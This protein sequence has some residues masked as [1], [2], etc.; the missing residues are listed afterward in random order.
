M[1]K[2]PVCGVMMGDNVARCFMCKYDFQKAAREGEDVAKKEAT[3][4]IKKADLETSSRASDKKAE[5]DKILADAKERNRL[6][7]ESLQQQLDEE[8]LRLEEEYVEIRKK[9]FEEKSKIDKELQAA[10]KQVEEE[11]K[12]IEDVQLLH[13]QAV[14]ESKRLA[15][16][17]G[18]VIRKEAHADAGKIIKEAN[19]QTEQL[20]VQVRKEYEEAMNLKD[21]MLTEAKIHQAEAEEAL[22]IQKEAQTECTRIVSITEAAKNNA[23]QELAEVRNK[24]VQELLDSKKQAELDADA[25]VAAA[26]AA[27]L[28]AVEETQRVILEIENTRKQ[29]EEELS[30]Y[31]NEAKAAIATTEEAQQKARKDEEE[32]RIIL[33]QLKA[34]KEK[35]EAE[36]I[37]AD[38]ALRVTAEELRA[39]Q[40]KR[41]KIEEETGDVLLMSEE[42][43]KKAEN[44]VSER[45]NELEN[46]RTV[47]E[48][49]IAQIIEESRL[50]RASAEQEAALLSKELEE[51]RATIQQA[52]ERRLAAKAETETMR[53]TTKQETEELRLSAKDEAE[54]I[55][56][57]AEKRAVALKEAAISESEK[58]RM[59]K[60][61][62][63]NI[64]LA[65]Q[66]IA[67]KE[68]AEKRADALAQQIEGSR[69]AIEQ[70]EEKIEKLRSSQGPGEFKPVSVPME[71]EVE[72]IK[73][74]AT[75]EV[76]SEAISRALT[77][78]G[79]GGWKLHSLVNDEGGRLQASLG[80]SEQYSLSSGTAIKEDRVILI[81]E[82]VALSPSEI[83]GTEKI[84]SSQA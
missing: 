80:A 20:A 14:V 69:K 25:R 82:R 22:R 60:Q 77:K 31:I 41:D 28:K 67:A 66:A 55:I 48:A 83:E 13:D 63:E 39:A 84:P 64:L 12:H 40:E 71:Y 52:E 49:E 61:I 19:D 46:T 32:A 30:Y 5:E 21:Q 59:A 9:A 38:E 57:A 4:H 76:D 42:A 70:M 51:A 37:K 72:I 47:T 1:K 26:E 16:A 15:L 45:L 29:G 44:E 56:I 43:R 10:R 81:F 50:T 24:A 74:K 65:G 54:Q 73:H 62:E 58:G 53:L 33:A 34:D 78:R 35:A 68:E 27:R 75:G 18:D 17:D 2:C 11:K 3:E 36:K 7:I 6:V 8:K 79:P 23:E